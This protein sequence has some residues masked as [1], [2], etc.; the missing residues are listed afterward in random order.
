MEAQ[1]KY[2]CIHGHYY[3]PPRENAWLEFVEVQDSAHPYHDWNQRITAECYGPNTSSRILSSSDKI[4]N[5]VNNFADTSFNIGPT[6]LSWLE[7]EANDVYKRILKADRKSRQ[8]FGGHGSALAQVYNHIIMPLASKEDKE[9]QVYWGIKDFEHRFKRKPMGMWLAETAVDTE[10]LEVLAAHEI[11]FTIL[12]PRQAKGIRKIGQTDWTKVDAGSLDTRRPYRCVLPSGNE[13]TL[14]FYDGERSQAVAF[15]KLLDSGKRFAESFTTGFDKNPD[16][17][18]LVHIA[19]DGESYGH[20]HRYGDMALAYAL[21]YIEFEEIAELTNYAQF[22]DMFPPTYEAQI[23]DN[24]SWSCVHGVERWRANCGCNSGG[25]GDWNQEWRQPLRVALDWLRDTA[26]TIIDEQMSRF[27]VDLRSMKNAYIEVM[28]SRDIENT[29]QFLRKYISNPLSSEDR[30]KVIRLLEAVRHLQLMYTSCAWFFDEISGMETVQVL[31]YANRAIQLIERESTH[32]IEDGFLTMLAE[33]KSN[34]A[35]YKNGKEI[36][37]AWINPKRLTLSS[38][39]MHYAVAS[40]F[41]EYPE[42]QTIYN[43]IAKSKIFERLYAGNHRLA[44]GFTQVNSKVTY[45]DKE[46]CFAVVYL[47]QN[48]IIG[49]FSDKIDEDTFKE[50][51]PLITTAFSESRLAD[52]I[53]LM[54]QYFGE[55]KF[56]LNNLF[57][58]DRKKVLDLIVEKGLKVADNY[59][60]D[61]Y[62]DNYNLM[63]ILKENDMHIPQMLRQNLEIVI[64]SEILKFLKSDAD[65]PEKLE[66]LAVEALKWKVVL[67]KTEMEFAATEK[68]FDLISKVESNLSDNRRLES[69]NGIFEQLKQLSITPDLWRIQN[70]YFKLG[71]EHLTDKEFAAE[72]GNQEDVEWMEAFLKLGEYINVKIN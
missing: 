20:H 36:Y 16:E 29:D 1:K 34:I 53:G 14:F 23:H 71:K 13:I 47:G 25:H 44:I 12:A 37:T 62:N 4:V 57:R 45:S 63:N 35:K 49:N 17:P 60:Q 40:L 30:T 69:M 66:N 31:Q 26:N 5:I 10:T 68:L 7:L 67:H 55:R 41:A 64:N 19:T 8:N 61:V 54:Q 58:D 3:Q 32:K 38:V 27:N 24:S 65:N 15:K 52:V 72:V 43:Y 22:L 18:Q 21:D 42:E 39:G 48:H 2:I 6:L 59:F 33:A 56:T 51:M 9:I 50:M 11:K 46:F 28:L 70:R